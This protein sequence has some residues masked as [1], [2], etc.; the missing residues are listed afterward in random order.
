[1]QASRVFSQ[2]DLLLSVCK[3]RAE[4]Q[5]RRHDKTGAAP[6]LCFLFFLHLTTLYSHLMH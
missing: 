3:S 2:S 6:T 4:E 1:M 5:A